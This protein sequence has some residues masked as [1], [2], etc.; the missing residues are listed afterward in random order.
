MPPRKS[1]SAEV[2]LDVL[3]ALPPGQKL[4]VRGVGADLAPLL[5]SG[6][7]VRVLRGGVDSVARGDVVLVRQG[8][9][10]VAQVVA[11]TTPWRTT[12]LVGAEDR[13]GGEVLGRVV[14]LRRG[15]WVVPLPRP[16]RPALWIAQRALAAAWARPRTRLVYRGVRDFFFSG[17]SR[18]LRRHLVGALEVR[19]LRA[20]DLEALLVFAG[21]RLVV[22]ASFL[23]RQLR[24]RWGLDVASRQGAAAGAL[25][26]RGRVHGFAWVDSYRQE[27][28]P[29]DGVWVR[30]LVVAPQARRMGVATRLLEC[31]LAEAHRQGEPRVQADVDEDNAASLRTFEGLGFRRASEALTRRT[32]EAWDAAGRSKKL[33]VLERDSGG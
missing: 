6:D 27:G 33:V 12:T 8:R 24:E 21:E 22:S 19:L 23:R 32:N 2:V 7:A 4:W 3:E 28:L 31:L 20:E 5:R 18:P 13:R 15:R 26:A 10:L 16:F 25:D 17:W 9:R 14:A 1:P 11:S 29:L 30:S